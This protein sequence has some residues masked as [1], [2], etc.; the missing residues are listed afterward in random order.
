MPPRPKS[1]GGALQVK[2]AVHWGWQ[3]GASEFE[4]ADDLDFRTLDIK[5]L[6]ILDELRTRP[7]LLA[8]AGTS[9]AQMASIAPVP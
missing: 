8:V 2:L 9:S 1:Q 3:A 4:I 7:T 6:G 5:K